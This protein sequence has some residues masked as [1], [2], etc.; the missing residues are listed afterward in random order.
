MEKLEIGKCYQIHSYKHNGKI[1]KSWDEAVLLD[2]DYKN[3]VYIFGNNQT[4]VTESDGRTWQTKEPAIL[5]FFSNKWYN[6]IGQ[7]KK[8]GIFYYCNLASPLIIEEGT[9]KYI[10]YDLDVKVFPDGSFKVVDRNEYNYHKKKMKYP[11]SIDTIV[12]KELS[13]LI[14]LIKKKESYFDKNMVKKYYDFYKKLVKED[15]NCNI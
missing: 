6:I 14:N 2:Y 11:L 9:I 13:N 4:T 5:F 15:K 3:G 12:N 7:Y 8:R 1:Y 10:D